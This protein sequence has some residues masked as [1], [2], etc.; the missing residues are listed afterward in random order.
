MRANRLLGILLR[1]QLHGKTTAGALADQFDVSIRTIYRDLQSLESTGVPI[2]TDRGSSGGV[3]LVEGY[4]TKLTGLSRA[5]IEALPF[6]QLQ[7]AASALG[8]LSA[9]EAARLKLL[10]ALPETSRKR[11]VRNSERFYFDPAGWYQ[12]HIAPRCLSLLAEAVWNG[13]HLEIDYESWT[14]RKIRTVDP[15]GLVLKGGSWYLVAASHQGKTIFKVE[16]IHSAR[17][18]EKPSRS[19]NF[20][21][22]EFWQ[23]EVS[24]FESSLRRV[25]VTIRVSPAAMSRIGELGAVAAEP[26]RAASTDECGRRTASIWVESVSHAAGQLLS[27]STDIE[28]L[29][30]AR[31]RRE[32]RQR[33]QHI[34]HLYQAD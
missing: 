21:L 29:A 2:W 9:A 18:L 6:I 22:A 34:A 15:L 8:S 17:L 24:R 5:E 1:L 19:E 27:F 7:A 12:R 3:S 30:P 4:Q 10:A 26:V 32:L 16:S 25:E 13:R 11:A 33:A 23:R 28:V 20:N 31:L 14:A